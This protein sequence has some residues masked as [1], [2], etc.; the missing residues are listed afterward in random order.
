MPEVDRWLAFSIAALLI[1]GSWGVFAN[2]TVRYVDGYSALV[3]E[4][5]GALGVGLAVLL[6]ITRSGGL[7]LAG[8]GILFGILTGVTYTL[9]LIFLFLALRASAPVAGQAPTGRVHTILLLTA[10]YPLVA[11]VINY[12]V[13]DEPLSLRQALGIVLGLAAVTLFVS[14]SS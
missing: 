9:G 7:D 5:I 6:V 8:R 14:G 4:V 11:G 12:L 10:L 13:L 3:F 2:L 1:W